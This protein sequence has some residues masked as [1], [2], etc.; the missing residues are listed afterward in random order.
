MCFGKAISSFRVLSRAFTDIYTYIN[1]DVTYTHVI[2]I[3]Y[4]EK[5]GKVAR[6]SHYLLACF[7]F[8]AN[9]RR[10]R[11]DKASF[12]KHV[13]CSD[14]FGTVRSEWGYEKEGGREKE[15]NVGYV[16]IHVYT[17]IRGTHTIARARRYVIPRALALSLLS[18]SLRVAW[19]RRHLFFLRSNNSWGQP[20]WEL[21]AAPSYCSTVALKRRLRDRLFRRSLSRIAS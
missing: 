17:Y 21:A 19:A 6:S 13:R 8:R 1:V 7:C 12:R 16:Y 11:F 20:F 14:V 10:Y 2:Y 5:E 15:R 9:H 4:R 3:M 18:S